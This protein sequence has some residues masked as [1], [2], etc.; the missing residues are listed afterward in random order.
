MDQELRKEIEAAG[1]TVK[2][3]QSLFLLAR[4]TIF[5]I[6]VKSYLERLKSTGKDLYYTDLE[7]FEKR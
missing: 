1:F 3:M 7:I 4:K 6:W 5:K 2:E